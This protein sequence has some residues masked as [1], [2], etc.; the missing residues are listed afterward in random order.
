MASNH[1]GKNY[2]WFWSSVSHSKSKAGR[3]A[4]LWVGLLFLT[5]LPN[6]VCNKYSKSFNSVISSEE[7]NNDF[8][9]KYCKLKNVS[10]FTITGYAICGILLTK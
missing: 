5:A 3:D 9:S 6:V 10:E 2:C 8:V 7:I 4:P 1:I